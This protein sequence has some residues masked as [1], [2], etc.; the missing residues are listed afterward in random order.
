[1][2]DSIGRQPFVMLTFLTIIMLVTDYVSRCFIYDGFPHL[3]VAGCTAIT[4]IMLPA[5]G[6]E[7]YQYVR[8]IL[9]AEERS[10]MRYLDAIINI[11]AALAIVVVLMSP[12]TS[13]V[14]YFGETG[15]YFRGDLFIMP[16]SSFFLILILADAFLAF[17]VHSLSRTSKAVLFA[18]PIPAI[19]GSVFAIVFPDVP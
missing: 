6:T 9:T 15:E 7:W 10:K 17:E 4:F 16:A 5:I 18:F 19:V 12:I 14:Y 1:M 13:W 8:N 11:L 3:A 2:D